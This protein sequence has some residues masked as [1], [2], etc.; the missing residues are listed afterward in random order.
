MALT[1]SYQTI[2][3]ASYTV[4]GSTFKVMLQAK[5]GDQSGNSCKVCYRLV[6]NAPKWITATTVNNSAVLNGTGASGWS[7]S[8]GTFS[9]NSGDNVIAEIISG[10]VSG[11]AT[12]TISGGYYMGYYNWGSTDLSGTAT[13][14]TFVVAPAKPTVSVTNNGYNSNKITYGASSFGTPSSGTV[15]LYGGTSA[16]PTTKITSKTTTGNSTYTQNSLTGNTRYYYRA[17]ATNGSATSDYSDVASIYTPC[18]PLSALSLSSQA[19]TAYNKVSAVLAYTRA[20]DGGAETRTGQYRY[21]TDGGNTYTDWK[22]FGTVSNTS[23]TFTITGLSTATSIRVQA[24]LSTPKGG[25]S[26]AKTLT[27]TSKSTHTA[28]NFSNFAYEDASSAAVAVSGSN[29]I[30]IQ[31]QSQPK[32]TISAT[33]KATANDGASVSGYTA[34]LNAESIQIAYSSSAAVSGSFNTKRPAASGTLALK[35]SAKDSLDL[36]TAVSKN[37]TV[38]PWAAP[39][40]NASATRQNNFESATTLKIAGTYSPVKVNNV[41]KNSIAVAY[42]YKKSSTSTWGDWIS[43]AVTISDSNFSATDLTLDFDN[44]AQWDIQVRVVDKFTTTIATLVLSVGMPALFI[45]ADGRCAVGQRPSRTMANGELGQLEV[46]G[47]YYG[48]EGVYALNSQITD[49]TPAGWVGMFGNGKFYIRYG[50]SG[51]FA[52]QPSQYGFL[53]TIIYGN[54]VMQ[55]WTTM[56][57]G[58]KYMRSGNQSG[59]KS[60]ASGAFTRI[61]TSPINGTDI[62]DGTITPRKLDNSSLGSWMMLRP[63][64][65]A[66]VKAECPAIFQS[67]SGGQNL[68]FTAPVGIT[69]DVSSISATGSFQVFG[70]EGYNVIYFSNA[71][72]TF[73]FSYPTPLLKVICYQ[74]NGYETKSGVAFTSARPAT[75]HLNGG[76]NFVAS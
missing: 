66:S 52:N 75:V 48:K 30:F 7:A 68:V 45:G 53:E 10:A 70:I 17:Q 37:V 51:L 3:E 9:L 61:A 8:G 54:D 23:G 44:T 49:D 32:V 21:S 27:F 22:S 60:D 34:N 76:A 36:A 72:T 25:Y 16:T 14:P 59:W 67:T 50:T 71:T 18:P 24:R 63:G 41:V 47:R 12:V 58:A 29:Q 39:V 2:K 46:Q 33:N 35:V 57:G 13:V 64:E 26:S 74:A 4:D 56:P 6:V 43:R 40:I 11:G 69:S 55:I 1:T 62:L 31:G 38:I 19:Y 65:K 20:S 15:N 73:E 5:Y 28:P 42:R